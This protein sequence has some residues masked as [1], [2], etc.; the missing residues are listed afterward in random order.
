MNVILWISYLCFLLVPIKHSLHMFQQNR[1]RFDRYSTWIKK[2]IMIKQKEIG[3]QF[4][5]LCGVY[6]LLLYPDGYL[7]ATLLFIYAYLDFKVETRKSYR[8]A[9]VYT[10]RVKRILVME[11]FL[12]GVFFTG[13][14]SLPIFWQIFFI[15]FVYFLP[16][17]FVSFSSCLMQ[18]IEK[19][20]A[21][22]YQRQAKSMLS[23]LPHLLIVG[24]GGSYGKTSTKNILYHL[25]NDTFMTLKTPHSYNNPMGIT[26]TIRTMLKPIHEV[27]LCEMGADHVHD[28][29][30]L[31]EFVQPSMSIVTSIGSQHLQTFHSME[32]IQKE[33]MQMIEKL[34]RDGIGFLNM[35][36]PWIVD[37]ALKNTCRIIWYGTNEKANY[38]LHNISYNKTH[39]S[40]SICYQNHN[41]L[42]TTPLLGKHNLQN[43]CGA[44]AIAH[45]LGISWEILQKKVELLPFVEHRLEK[46]VYKDYILLDDAYNSNPI[47]ARYAFDVLKQMDGQRIVITPGCIDLGDMQE[48]E[49]RKLGVYVTDCADDIILVGAKQTT[50]YYEGIKQTE[51]PKSH[52]YIANDF[53]QALNIFNKIKTKGCIVLFENDLP[54]AFHH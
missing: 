41:I 32:N 48:E 23:A 2:D 42:F 22:Y 36:E 52:V 26:K 3:R 27:F 47:G 13:Y 7:L 40:F 21:Q 49:N 11:L 12:I 33:K 15:P 51:F 17:I 16:W 4:L 6:F 1:Y 18:P 14:L 24:I 53:T 39:T 25:V 50:S 28:I 9:L 46:K 37:Y 35:D 10:P 38:Y 19:K 45:T 8:K 30:E 31:M 34:P 20:I 29:E 44:I 5:Y 43:I 54:D